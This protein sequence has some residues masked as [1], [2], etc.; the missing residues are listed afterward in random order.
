[1][2]DAAVGK[3]SY[4]RYGKYGSKYGYD[5]GY[6]YENAGGKSHRKIDEAFIE[7][8]LENKDEAAERAETHD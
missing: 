6:G 1:M 2:T 4:K 5:Y 7:A 3:G 8:T